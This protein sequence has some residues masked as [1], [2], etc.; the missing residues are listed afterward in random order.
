MRTGKYPLLPAT[1]KSMVAP[2]EMAEYTSAHAESKSEMLR[3]IFEL[4]QSAELNAHCRCQGEARSLPS[5]IRGI[6]I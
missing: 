3:F 4:V 2:R 5:L 6:L 1:S